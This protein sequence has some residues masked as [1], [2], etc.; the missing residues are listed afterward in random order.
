MELNQENFNRRLALDSTL[1]E[2]GWYGGK[3]KKKSTND[4]YICY[5]LQEPIKLVGSECKLDRSE[6]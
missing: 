2:F 5:L 6:T 3:S 4:V 1:F